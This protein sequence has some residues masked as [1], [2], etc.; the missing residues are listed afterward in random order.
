M[1][2]IKEITEKK[3]NLEK[4]METALGAAKV[5]KPAT[6][7]FDEAYG[8]YLAA[9][10]QMAKIPSEFAAARMAENADAIKSAGA[11]IAETI[12][13]LCAGLKVADLLG[14]PVLTVVYSMDAEGKTQVRINPKVRLGAT[15]S[16]IGE[17]KVGQGRVKIVGPDGTEYSLTKFVIAHAPE[18]DR[19]KYPHALVAT[20]AKFDVF[21]TKYKLVGFK[22]QPAS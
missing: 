19:G 3:S 20:E 1:P 18:A 13:K 6:A 2:T 21:C 14:E 9:K 10:A 16:T 8:R 22:Y 4:Q 17:R 7:E 5:L 12:T 15:K 11:A